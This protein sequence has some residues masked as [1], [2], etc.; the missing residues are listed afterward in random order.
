MW[1]QAYNAYHSARQTKGFREW[2]HYLNFKRRV[3]AERSRKND[4]LPKIKKESKGDRMVWMVDLEDKGIADFPIWE[5]N[6]HVV[7]LKPRT[8]EVSKA[9]INCLVR[10][11]R[12]PA[13]KECLLPHY[14]SPDAL[15]KGINYML[16]NLTTLECIEYVKGHYQLTDKMEELLTFNY[17]DQVLEAVLMWGLESLHPSNKISDEIK[18]KAYSFIYQ[19]I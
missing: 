19:T 6:N 8:L 2:G 16:N 7:G 17:W 3:L 13:L 4:R 18:L 14:P 12:M 5:P 1:F 9:V 15:R 10:P 11:K